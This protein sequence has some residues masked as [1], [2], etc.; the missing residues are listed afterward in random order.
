MV[1]APCQSHKNGTYCQTE[2]LFK[3]IKFIP[4]AYALTL[5]TI[6]ISSLVSQSVCQYLSLPPQSDISGKSEAYRV[7][8]LGQGRLDQGRCELLRNYVAYQGTVLINVLQYW[9]TV[10]YK[11]IWDCQ[12]KFFY[13]LICNLPWLHL[14]R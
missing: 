7:P 14:T 9:P 13:P 1:Q 4:R 8:L 10:L 3:L 11:L 2:M 6:V 5:F 12:L